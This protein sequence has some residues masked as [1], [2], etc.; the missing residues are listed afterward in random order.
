MRYTSQGEEAAIGLYFYKA[1]W[2][3]AE[4]RRFVQADTIV[5]EPG[6]PQSLNRYSYV[7]NNPLRY[8]DPTGMFTEQE[9][10]SW[11]ISKEWIENWR[12]DRPWWALIEAA[13]L[14]DRVTAINPF[15]SSD[16][17]VVEGYFILLTWE[18]E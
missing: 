2:Y 11:G 10:L 1:R 18:F 4:L 16:P 13:Q 5:P 8:I 3:D 17:R 14:H 15:T 7:L 12:K 6:N 9:L